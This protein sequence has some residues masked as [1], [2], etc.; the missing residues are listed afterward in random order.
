M[1]IIYIF[2]HD[3]VLLFILVEVAVVVCP[4]SLLNHKVHTSAGRRAD[5]RA[6]A[7]V[8]CVS[9]GR[10]EDTEQRDG[11]RRRRVVSISPLCLYNTE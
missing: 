4:C 2:D 9:S 8:Y 1:S 3:P 5:V 6:V 7:Q 11:E 10:A